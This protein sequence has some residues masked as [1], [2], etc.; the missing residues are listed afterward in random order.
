MIAAFKSD[1]YKEGL[2]SLL[3]HEFE[4]RLQLLRRANA[5]NHNLEEANLVG[6][7]NLGALSTF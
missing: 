2:I 7:P 6:E 3:H 1:T 5:I 4:E